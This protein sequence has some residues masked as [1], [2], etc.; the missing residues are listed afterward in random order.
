MAN[1]NPFGHPDNCQ[2]EDCQVWRDTRLGLALLAELKQA[3]GSQPQTKV[4]GNCGRDD[5]PAGAKFCQHC[6]RGQGRSKQKQE[7]QRVCPFCGYAHVSDT[8]KFCL[9]CGQRQ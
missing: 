4:C 7:E 3:K 9:R 5:V 1:E 6:G 2:C 8:A